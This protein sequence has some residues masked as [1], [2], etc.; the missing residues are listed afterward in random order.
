MA[1]VTRRRWLTALAAALLCLSPRS[2][3]SQATSEYEVKAAYLYGFGRFTEWPSW[4]PANS[5]PSFVICVLGTDPFGRALDDVTANAVMK[6]RP[7]RVQRI[8]SP[9]DASGCHTLFIG[10]SEDVRL[11]KILDT[12]ATMPVLTVSDTPNFAQRGGIV[13]FFVD[14]RRVRFNVNMEAAQKTSLTLNSE[15]LRVSATVIRGRRAER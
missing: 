4:T 1:S 14:G 7:V 8:A 10:A 13:G 2:G 9:Q 6:D 3:S 12:V 11:S 5:G 15:L